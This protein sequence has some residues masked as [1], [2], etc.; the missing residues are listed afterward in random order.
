MSA[1]KKSTATIDPVGVRT[2]KRQRA[3]IQSGSPFLFEG[4]DATPHDRV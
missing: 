1:V 2:D 3:A 4:Q